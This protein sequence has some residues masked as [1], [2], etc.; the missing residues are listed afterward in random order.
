MERLAKGTRCVLNED[1]AEPLFCNWFKERGTCSDILRVTD[2]CMK[3]AEC[4]TGWCSYGALMTCQYKKEIGD[5]CI[6]SNQC[7]SGYCGEGF[8]CSD[9]KPNGEGCLN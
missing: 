1:C 5:Q 8:Q 4:E 3:D 7:V 6:D 9:R 2:R